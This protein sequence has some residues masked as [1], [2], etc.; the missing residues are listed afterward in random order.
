[1]KPQFVRIAILYSLFTGS[2][3]LT[4]SAQSIGTFVS[5]TPTTQTQNLVIPS[6]HRFQRIIKSGDPLSLGGTLGSNTDFT[7]YVP[8]SGSSTNG[9]LSISNETTPAGVAIL[10]ISYNNSNHTWAVNNSGNVAFPFADIGETSRF[11]S[12]TV[13]PNNTIIVCEEDVSGIDNN[14]DG[15]TDRGWLIEINPATRTV[16]NQD[17]A[18]GVDK[19]WAIGRTNHENA[20]IR[21]DNMVLYSGADDA[22][23]GYLYKFIPN[24]PGNFSSGTLYVL[25]TT[26]SL[27]NGTWRILANGTQA[28]RNNI[29]A[30]STS[31][32][33]YNFNGIE[34]VEIGPDGKIYF[35]AKA[36][37]KV[38]RFTDNGTFGN[39]NDISGLEVFAG[40]TNYPTITNYDIDGAGPLPLEPWGRG[41]DNLAFDGE[42]NLWVCQDAIVASD[43]N[44]IWVVGPTH[45]Q[46][47]PQVRVF[48]TTPVRCEPTGITFTPDYKF[49]FISFMGPNGSNTSS[50][51]DA[52]G[53]NVVFNTHTTVVIARAEDL[54]P[55][56]TLPVTI[57]AFEARPSGTGE[58]LITW[59][60]KDINNHDYFSVERSSNGYEFEE[61]HRNN[62]N[63]NG[64][65]QHAFSFTDYNFP[66]ADIIYYRIKQCDING[67]CR[68][69]SI[70]A[71]K[72]NNRNQIIQI[73]PQPAI[74]K[75]NV[76]YN[77]YAKGTGTII[78]SDMFGKNVKK[79][80]YNL[81]KGVQF[82]EISTD[83][84]GSGMYLVT[85]C[86]KNFQKISQ[87]F[88][89]E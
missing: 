50:Q 31:A 53:V 26:A 23:L 37:G 12:G 36:E 64:A 28:E 57:T 46:A 15:Y 88:I 55:L 21:N 60:A 77:S 58:V 24:V 67:S 34:D 35:C 30:A 54:G 29:R 72:M 66:V 62:E 22:S 39:A 2:Y 10:G 13:T 48:A 32:G 17:G 20:A 83:K 38:Y 5:V 69:T 8:V 44:H 59:T 56:I 49:I 86:D 1:M 85:I 74:N 78:I 52:A 7:G 27:G 63:M 80:T 16:I 65:E 75:L 18:G 33:A 4:I 19:L 89:K 87:L 3:S 43:R 11:C 81:S 9:Y 41:N 73:Y 70:K 82:I 68:Y 76:L 61:I 45:T 51:A 40:N 71:V 42:G 84:L 79:E 47:S 14:G 6:T 25:Q